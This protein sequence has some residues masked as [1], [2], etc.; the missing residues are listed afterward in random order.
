MLCASVFKEAPSGERPSTIVRHYQPLVHLQSSY[1][2]ISTAARGNLIPIYYVK[3]SSIPEIHNVLDLI[4]GKQ[5]CAPVTSNAQR[6][7]G[8]VLACGFRDM[9]AITLYGRLSCLSVCEIILETVRLNFTKFSMRV[10]CDRGLVE[11]CFDDNALRYVFPVL[12]RTSYF[13][14]IGDSEIIVFETD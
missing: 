11:L 5:N 1:R 13:H 12:R 6:K 8:E 7:L 2:A 9:L 10:A 14:I 3:T 4:V